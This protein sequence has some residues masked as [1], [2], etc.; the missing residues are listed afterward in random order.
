MYK[1]YRLS[2]V[3]MIVFWRKKFMEKKYLVS[4]FD[5]A[6]HNGIFYGKNVRDIIHQCMDINI[7]PKSIQDI[8]E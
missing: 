1:F 3:E 4:W 6:W 2:I 5:N 7:H 8:E